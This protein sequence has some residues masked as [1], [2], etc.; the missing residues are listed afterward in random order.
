MTLGRHSGQAFIKDLRIGADHGKPKRMTLRFADSKA[1]LLSANAQLEMTIVVLPLYHP[2]AA[3][4][5]GGLRQTLLDDFQ[6]VPK[7]VQEI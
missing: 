1:S 7:L 5:N 2:A 4:Y 3:L 6:S